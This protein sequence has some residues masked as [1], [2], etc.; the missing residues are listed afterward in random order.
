MGSGGAAGSSGAQPRPLGLCVLAGVGREL[1]YLQGGFRVP[2]A[3]AG[4]CVPR[5]QGAARR[6]LCLAGQLRLSPLLA[7]GSSWAV[8]MGEQISLTFRVPGQLVAKGG[9]EMHSS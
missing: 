9:Q 1:Q 4:S 7:C 6:L 5:R 3:W 8:E 2:L